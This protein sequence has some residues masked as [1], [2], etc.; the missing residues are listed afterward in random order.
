MSPCAGYDRRMSDPDHVAEDLS[1]APKRSIRTANRITD[2][3]G[4]VWTAVLVATL[5]GVWLTVGFVA[6]HPKWW[7][8]IGTCGVPMFTL[9]LVFTL[10]HTENH[11]NQALQVKLD[12]IIRA[13]GETHDEMM[14]VEDASEGDLDSLQEHFTGQAEDAASRREAAPR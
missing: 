3:A 11:N 8:L 13:L 6:D 4:S 14:G 1:R 2:L 10:Q 12:E 9:A 7:E 5:V